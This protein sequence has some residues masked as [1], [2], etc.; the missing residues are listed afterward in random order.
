MCHVSL[1]RKNLKLSH[2]GCN[3][4]WHVYIFTAI[5]DPSKENKNNVHNLLIWSL[6]FILHCNLQFTFNREQCG[7]SSQN[8]TSPLGLWSMTSC[9]AYCLSVNTCFIN[10]FPLIFDPYLLSL[11]FD[12]FPFHNSVPKYI[13]TYIYT[14]KGTRQFLFSI[15]LRFCFKSPMSRYRRIEEEKTDRG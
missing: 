3:L 14:Y 6:S 5:E 4:V 10:F 9:P 11:T 15:Y 12:F 13:Y 8:T 1:W 7:E 2:H